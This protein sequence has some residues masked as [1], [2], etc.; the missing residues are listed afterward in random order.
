MT[1]LVRSFL[2]FMIALALFA[3]PKLARGQGQG[4][5]HKEKDKDRLERGDRDDDEGRGE[6]RDENH[7][8]PIF[9]HRDRDIIIQFYR[10]R[11]SN[12]PPGLAKRNGNLPPGLEKHLERDGTLP[13]GLQKRVEPLPHALEIRL[14]RLPSIYRRGRIGPDVIIYNS[15]TR[16]VVDVIR[17]VAAVSGR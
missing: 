3:T 7:G 16:A 10:T 12:L 2:L 17:D 13:P 5:P 1:R 9:R 14:P 11:Y 4:N 15:K 6:G 8:R